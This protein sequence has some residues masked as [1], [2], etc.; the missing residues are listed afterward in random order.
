MMSRT[1]WFSMLLVAVPAM[2]WTPPVNLSNQPSGSRAFGPRI[3][4]DPMGHSHLFWAGGPD[5]ASNWRVY[6]QTF[7]GASW[8]APMSL[9]GPNAN[10]PDVA[11]D[12]N[13]TVHLVYE[14]AAE[15]NIW[16]RRK[17]AGGS[18]TSPLNLR[19]GGR[20]I[21]PSIAVNPAGD[22]IIVAWHEDDQVGDEWDIFVN[23]H[24]NGSWSGTQNI[25][26]NATL[27]SNARAAIDV[28]GNMHVAWSDGHVLYRKRDLGGQWGLIDK[29]HHNTKRCNISD[30]HTDAAGIVHAVY[31]VDDST[32]WEIWYRNHDGIAWSTAVNVSQRPG[33]SNDIDARIRS[34]ALGKLCV[35]W[36]DY[37]NVLSSS[38]PSRAGPWSPAETIVAN[39]YLA[40]AP[41]LT[42]DPGMTAR[43][44]WQSRPS[45]ADNWNIYYADKSIGT[46]GPTGT[47]SGEVRDQADVPLAGATVSTGNAAGI[48]NAAGQYAFSA[49]VGTYTVMA[50]KPYHT[51]QSVSNVDISQGQTTIRNFQISAIGPGPVTD[52]AIVQGNLQNVVTWTH[53]ASPQT[54]GARIRVRSDGVYPTGPDDGTLLAD[55]SGGAGSAGGLTHTG[56]TNGVHYLY[57]VFAYSGTTTR[58]YAPAEMVSGTPAGPGDYDRDGDV[59]QVDWGYF[60]L[61]LSGPFVPQDEP[62]CQRMKL[63]GDADVDG[64][65]VNLFL[66]C[67]SGP[68][69]Y[70]NPHCLP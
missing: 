4:A 26:A 70:A 29:I 42:I 11:I 48:T 47:L 25:S 62:E 46:P 1:A 59:D 18:W 6:Y 20:S 28:Q 3:A 63:D 49:P 37:D 8:S 58:A 5:P 17:A 33:A 65:D 36:H 53:P 21:A 19:T 43:A 35:V 45:Q 68:G 52:I 61:C 2:A 16:Y 60:Q 27:S 56:L 23:V 50:S 7:N 10:R 64:D 40:T 34:D 55:V 39:K 24:Q 51:S 12:G 22:R 9:S 67:V 44:V 41:H 32:G 66:M 14:E 69:V 57:S 31:Q 30:L 13:G 54:A 15:R 38:A